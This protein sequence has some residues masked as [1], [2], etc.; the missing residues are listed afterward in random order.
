MTDF[1]GRPADESIPGP[2]SHLVEPLSER[3]LS[4]A[5]YHI[6]DQYQIFVN[7]TGTFGSRTL[8]APV[9]LQYADSYTPY[10]PFTATEG[11]LHFVTLRDLPDPGPRYIDDPLARAEMKGKGG[12]QFM[13][14]IQGDVPATNQPES[15]SQR[16]DG[17]SVYRMKLDP[18]RSLEGPSP[19]GSIAQYYIVIG[20]S[21][22][23]A[24]KE[25][26]WLTH[27]RVNGDEPAPIIE[28]GMD[29]L[30]VLVLGFREPPG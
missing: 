12:G 10:G 1:F 26:P 3:F 15:L 23:Y 13:L 6:R 16:G 9:T 5:H 4:P 30:D 24:G 11:T 2:Q 8:K 29:G 7:S 22:V 21:L 19:A 27:L 14:E 20:G 18:G 28:S 17:V 25:H